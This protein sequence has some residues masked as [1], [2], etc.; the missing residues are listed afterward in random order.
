MAATR[1]RAIANIIFRICV[2]PFAPNRDGGQTFRLFSS[3]EA[4]FFDFFFGV[5]A[6]G[7]PH[8]HTALTPVFFGSPL[9]MIEP[10]RH[11]RP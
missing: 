2:S 9:W 10:F 7:I 6:I 4:Y 11:I 5:S 8:R 1:A 3:R